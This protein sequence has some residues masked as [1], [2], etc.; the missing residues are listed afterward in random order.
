M[1]KGHAISEKDIGQGPHIAPLGLDGVMVRFSATLSE[2]ANRAAIGFHAAICEAGL[3]GFEE[4]AISLTSVYV[5]FD[6]EAVF[7]EAFFAQVRAIAQSCNWC[8]APLPKGRKLW[9]IPAAFG[10]IHGPQL[11]EAAELAGLSPQAAIDQICANPVRV[12]TIGFAPGQPYLGEL[13]ENWHIPRQTQLTDQVPAG[14]LTVAIRQL[15][16]FAMPSPTGWRQIARTAFRPYQP[17]GETPFVLSA[18]DEVR[19]EPICA[20]EYAALDADDPMGGAR[21]EWIDHA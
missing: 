5:R 19:F 2:A 20:D 4:A 3:R 11:N 9:T 10:G 21:F 16:L 7:Y 12:L 15:V 8:D 13:P 17:H 18:G 14:A 6:P 1:A